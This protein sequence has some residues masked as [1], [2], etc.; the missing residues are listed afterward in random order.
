[1]D[2]VGG[3]TILATFTV[4]AALLPMAFVT[5]LM[6]PY[7]RP[8]PSTP[9]TGMLISLAVAFMFTPW[10]YQRL[11]GKRTGA[12]PRL[13]DTHGDAPDGAAAVLRTGHDAVS[14]RR[15]RAAATAGCCSA[16]SWSLIVLLG[17]AGG[18][19]SVVI[20]K[21]LPFDNK[22]EFQVVVDMPEGTPLEQTARVLSETG[23]THVATVPEVTDY[24]VYA[25]TAAPINFNGLVRQYYL[26]RAPTRAIS[27]STCWTSTIATARATTSPLAAA[28][29]AAGDRRK[30]DAQRQ[31]RRGAAGT[32]GAVAAGGGDLRPRLRR[33]AA[34]SR[35]QVR[36]VF[37]ATPDIVDV[38]DTVGA[39]QQRKLHR[40]GR[41]GQARPCWGSPSRQRCSGRW[42]RC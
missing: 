6:G 27:R 35:R 15:P 20:L 39:P 3:P 34:A 23:A 22:S 26:R 4:I 12:S 25:G 2:E 36:K 31:D 42:R 8:S 7:M 41:P 28:R 18:G 19:A 11:L 29:T 17:G 37:E 30:L 10:L 14:R 9:R 16:P 32:A 40:R 13:A 38:D 21:M 1:M 33:P 5:G 24:Q